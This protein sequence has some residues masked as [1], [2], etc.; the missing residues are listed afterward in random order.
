MTTSKKKKASVSNQKGQPLTPNPGTITNRY[1]MLNVPT[2]DPK[3]SYS[4]VASSN[5][6]SEPPASSNE[7]Q[8]G[9]MPEPS[10]RALMSAIQGLTFRF[11]DRDEHLS[12]QFKSIDERFQTLTP[13]PSE[14]I[15]PTDDQNGNQDNKELPPDENH[16]QSDDDNDASHEMNDH[17]APTSRRGDYRSKFRPP[18]SAESSHNFLNQN[19]F[20]VAI[21]GN[22]TSM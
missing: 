4:A 10:L 9:T 1:D 14:N 18:S 22:K 11:D 17:P 16:I 13:S 8:E 2:T 15:P 12:D 21:T 5:R 19:E 3:Q 7:S 6:V 20:Y